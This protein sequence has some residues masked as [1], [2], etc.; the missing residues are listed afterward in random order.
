[1]SSFAVIIPVLFID[2]KAFKKE[3]AQTFRICLRLL[4]KLSDDFDCGHDS[5][6]GDPAAENQIEPPG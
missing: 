2:S 6:N 3:K 5:R 1:M 4:G